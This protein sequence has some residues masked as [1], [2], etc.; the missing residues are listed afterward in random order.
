[1]YGLV[2]QAIQDLVTRK[3][4]SDAWESICK[5]VG[6]E[7]TEF[8]PMKSYSDD[9]TYRLVGAVCKISQADPG[10]WLRSLGDHWITFT[11]AEGYGEMMDMFGRDLRSCLRN[12]NGMHGHMG[13]MMPKLNP[14]R[15]RV[16]DTASDQIIVHYYSH[17]EG[18]APMVIGLL[19]GLARR[20]GEQV[21]I[22][23]QAKGSRSDHDE[24]DIR[25]LSS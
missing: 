16:E 11:A 4:G 13:A 2:N 12:L 10:N 21:E 23:H 3:H 1:M 22:S 14:P 18:L 19:D 24:F 25:F 17:R 7:G 6:L 8:E 5:E 15:F 20:F 9:L